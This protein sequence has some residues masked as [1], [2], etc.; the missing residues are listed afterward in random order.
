MKRVLITG[1]S[2]FIGR[3]C[4]KPL[5][6]NNYE[7]D[8]VF[9]KQPTNSINI[10]NA[11]KWHQVDLLDWQQSELLVKRLQ[12]THLLHLAWYTA[13]GQYWTSIENIGWVQASLNLL[14]AF[15]VNG[16]QRAV[17]AGSCAEYDWNYGY[18]SERLTPLLPTTL[19]GTCKHALQM[20]VNAFAD[21]MEL[22]TA[23]GRVFFLYGP[24]EYPNRLVPAV[25]RS[26][27]VGQTAL[28]SH[29]NQIRDF[30]YVQDAAEAFVALLDS[31]VSGPVNIA[32]GQPVKLKELIY[33]IAGIFN[34][35]DLVQLGAISALES[36]PPLLVADVQ[37]LQNEVKWKPR[38]DLETGLSNTIDWWRENSP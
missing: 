37:R 31:N 14:Q 32:S 4:L 15:V 5:L 33:K 6:V 9:S 2:G 21:Q 12:P 7:V 8:A 18:C 10:N 13:P 27:L 34:R 20:M 30:L 24:H 28:C 25:I 19:Y 26:L 3:H 38:Y 36:E 23:W 11:V 16:G 17:I 22:S 1:A 29:G 35:P